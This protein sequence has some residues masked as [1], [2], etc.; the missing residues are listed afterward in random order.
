M[1]S[2][3]WSLILIAW[4][5]LAAAQ[6]PKS[7]DP[8]EGLSFELRVDRQTTGAGHYNFT[9]FGVGASYGKFTLDAAALLEDRAGSFKG[10]SSRLRYFPISYGIA[11]GDR[12]YP[13]FQYSFVGRWKTRLVPELEGLFHSGDPK[14]EDLGRYRTFEHYGGFGV[15]TFVLA[16]LYVDLGVGLGLY[17]STL[18]NEPEERSTNTE[19]FRRKQGASVSLRAGLGYYF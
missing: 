9:G 18:T 10:L 3:C 16:G 13:Y 14:S 7:L 15:Q 4:G 17:S 11:F 8:G 5:S 2:S 19:R 1:R 6:G 12:V